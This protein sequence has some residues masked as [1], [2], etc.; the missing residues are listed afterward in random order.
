MEITKHQFYGETY[1]QKVS[2]NYDPT[3]KYQQLLGKFKA[4][5]PKYILTN[6]Q[7]QRTIQCSSGEDAVAATG[8]LEDQPLVGQRLDTTLNLSTILGEN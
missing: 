8:I 4:I 1:G 5:F 3:L 6:Q 2:I 7:I